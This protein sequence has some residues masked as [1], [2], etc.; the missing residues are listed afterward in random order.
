M[1]WVIE[2]RIA[3][4]ALSH[5]FQKNY[6]VWILLFRDAKGYRKPTSALRRPKDYGIFYHA[7]EARS[8]LTFRLGK[9]WM[10]AS[11]RNCCSID[12]TQDAN[13]SC[14]ASAT[15]AECKAVSRGLQAWK[16]KRNQLH[17]NQQE[18][19]DFCALASSVTLRDEMSIKAAKACR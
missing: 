5:S 9:R 3:G 15:D 4:L 18:L 14:R 17:G 16:G 10:Y 8:R 2:A 7:S 11:L 1:P 13:S 6:S 19:I 12:S